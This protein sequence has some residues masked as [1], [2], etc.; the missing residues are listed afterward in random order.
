MVLHRPSN[1]S[2]LTTAYFY[3]YVAADPL[4]YSYEGCVCTSPLKPYYHLDTTGQ[5]Y[6]ADYAC[7]FSCKRHLHLGC[8]YADIVFSCPLLGTLP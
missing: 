6:S 8:A 3:N 5:L 1:E 7:S 2:D 4:L